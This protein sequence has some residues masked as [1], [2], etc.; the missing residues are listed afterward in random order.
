[1]RVLIAGGTGAIGRRLIPLLLAQGHEV[2]TF[3]RSGRPV[4][5]ASSIATNALDPAAVQQVVTLAQPDVVINLLTAIPDPVNPRKM[6]EQFALTNQL[7]GEGTR[8]LLAC[9]PGPVVAESIAFAYAPGDG[10]AD[11][12]APLWRNPPQQFAAVLDGVRSLEELTRAAG[13][14]V[15]RVGHL[16]GPGTTFGPGGGTRKVVQSHKLPVVGGGT[17]VFSFAHVDDVAEAFAAALTGPPGT[18]NIADSE[19]A[20]VAAWLPSYAEGLGAKPPGRVP[21]GLAKLAVGGWG[22]A[23]M[24]Q[25][26]GADN[27]RARQD[28]GWTPS[29]PWSTTLPV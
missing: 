5:G 3:S 7:R 18:Y 10:L 17:A 21:A 2:T 27:R 28:L 13:G 19:P 1:M 15:L 11:E 25:L 9:A 23:F 20:P 22:V 8:N 26:R 4:V 12:D 14:T 16:H 6:G 24:T 29:R